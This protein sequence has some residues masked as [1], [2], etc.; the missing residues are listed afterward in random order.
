MTNQHLINVENLKYLYKFYN[1]I[2]LFFKNIKIIMERLK[3]FL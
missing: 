3:F 2:K 1:Q